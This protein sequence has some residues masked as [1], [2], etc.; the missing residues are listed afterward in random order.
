MKIKI[1]LCAVCSLFLVAC[2]SQPTAPQ[3]FTMAQFGAVGDGV[4]NDAPALKKAFQ[5]LEHAGEPATLLFQ[6]K[7]YRLGKQDGNDAQFDFSGMENIEVD[8]QGA[9]LII[10]PV[11]GVARF[12]NSRNITF[13]NF[14]IQHDPLPF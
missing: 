6:K 5:A 10:H 9:T 8:G 11:H 3:V 14:V 12:F 1:H 4:R 2:A 13:K 7:T